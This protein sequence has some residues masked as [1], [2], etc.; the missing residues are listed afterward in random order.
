[1][2]LRVND[3]HTFQSKVLGQCVINNDELCGGHIAI[4][5]KDI[6]Q[7]EKNIFEKGVGVGICQTKLSRSLITEKSVCNVIQKNWCYQ[8]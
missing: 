3:S 1:M 4:A 2:R 5:D 6:Q 8:P 7:K